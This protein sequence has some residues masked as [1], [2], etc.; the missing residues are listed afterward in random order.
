[1]F[2][3]PEENHTSPTPRAHTGVMLRLHICLAALAGAALGAP[4]AEKAALGPQPERSNAE[5][6][7]KP[8]PSK[9]AKLASKDFCAHCP[10][11]FK[12][13]G[14]CAALTTNDME[15]LGGIFKGLPSDC[16]ESFNDKC[17]GPEHV[18]TIVATTC[19]DEPGFLCTMCPE[20]FLEKGGCTLLEMRDDKGLAHVHE[21]LPLECDAKMREQCGGKTAADALVTAECAVRSHGLKLPVRNLIMN[22]GWARP[23]A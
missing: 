5:K 22:L 11:V 18:A 16:A 17:G 12:E 23:A 14:G 21:S 8:K 2:D 9:Q 6:P 1:M 19:A 20:L 13:A 7:Q 3:C 4:V 15:K 10:A